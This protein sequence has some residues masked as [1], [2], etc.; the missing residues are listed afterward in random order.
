MPGI[1]I[2]LVYIKLKNIPHHQSVRLT[3]EPCSSKKRYCV[4]KQGKF[5]K[6]LNL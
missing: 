2:Q 1:L 3:A 4:K 5:E 6:F